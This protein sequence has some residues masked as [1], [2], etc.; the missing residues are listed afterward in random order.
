MHSPV[1]EQVD[2]EHARRIYDAARHPK[3]FVSL[4]G[5]DHLLLHDPEDARWAGAMLAAWAERFLDTEVASSPPAGKPAEGSL[6][7]GT[8]EVSGGRE[9]YRQTV[10]ARSHEWYADE[11]AEVGGTDVGPNPYELLLAGLG[12]C[13]T[14]TLR[15]YADRKGMPLEGVRVRLRHSKIHARD[16]EECESETGKIDLIE[17]QLD[18]I[19]DELTEEQRARLEQIS[20]MCPVH[21]TLTSETTVRTVASLE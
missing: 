11:P 21:R 9:H 19:G 8:V 14:I 7:E 4:D 5:A 2:V 17:K 16:C 10:R 18:L 3:S 15:M 20:A 1:D 6:P 12:A 13:T